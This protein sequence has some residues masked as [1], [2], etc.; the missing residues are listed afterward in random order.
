MPRDHHLLTRREAVQGRN[1]TRGDRN[2]DEPMQRAYNASTRGLSFL[3]VLLGLVLI[4]SALA[5]GGGALA[6]GVVIGFA[7]L[8]AGAGRFW[9]LRR[10]RG[11]PR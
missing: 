9:L 4:I 11:E 6:L 7:F 3:L 8:L 2:Y 10:V 1:L 5:R